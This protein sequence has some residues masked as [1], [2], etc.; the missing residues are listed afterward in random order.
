[1]TAMMLAFFRLFAT[2]LAAVCGGVGVFLVWASFYIPE[3]GAPAVVLLG[4]AL[5]LVAGR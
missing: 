1:M 2:V 4:T 5:A 3:F